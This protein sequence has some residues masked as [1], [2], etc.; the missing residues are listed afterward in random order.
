MSWKRWLQRYGD[1]ALMGG[2]LL[3]AAMLRTNLNYRSAFVDEAISLYG[4]WSMLQ[5]RH[6]FLLNTYMGWPLITCIPLGLMDRVGGLSAAR[7]LSA[8]FGVLTVALVMLTARRL[9]GRVAGYLAG[10]IWAVSDI[11]IFLSTFA[12]ADVFSLFFLSAGFYA[13]AVAFTGR[14][15]WLYPTGSLLLVL[16]VLA[17]YNAIIPVLVA[18]LYGTALMLGAMVRITDSDTDGWTLHMNRVRLLDL[19]LGLAP[20]ILLPLY[21]FIVREA[22]LE[23]W[24]TQVLVK[25]TPHAG[26]E[27]D[28][29]NEFLIYTWLPLALG[30]PAL[31]VREKRQLNLGL[32][33]VG[34]SL[35]GYHLLN[36]DQ[37]T[38]FKL[39]A[40]GLV[41]LAPLGA[42]GLITLVKL[43]TR[44]D[45]TLRRNALAGLA[46]VMMI[47]LGFSGQQRLPGLRS[48]WS[49]AS[50][51]IE[52]LRQEVQE[53]DILLM[54][55]G[56][57]G[58]YYLIARGEP[59]RIPEHVFDTWWYQ[60]EQ[61]SGLEA[62]Q[63]GITEQRFAWIIFDYDF[64]PELHEI[65]FEAMEGRYRLETTFPAR[66]Y[67]YAGRIDLFA[68][69]P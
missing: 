2:I 7:G 35:L 58:N 45:E 37:S 33:L 44:R 61:G 4:G 39:T 1:R 57:V 5:G 60:D 69:I 52:F 26:I 18:T 12:Y 31:M 30:L 54:E 20:F 14:K 11:A 15:R 40:Y 46:V 34:V 36:R 48:Y 65:F 66:R 8:V 3:L 19:A 27:M 59:G 56:Q 42:A 13:W 41:T 16:G 25:S 24:S 50:E 22:L 43:F 23:V 10:G 68:P 47:Y 51:V 67:G 49:D 17:K 32:L 38:V 9:Y 62:F 55:G 64:T 28:I 6:T 29:L 21:A 63:R 53:G